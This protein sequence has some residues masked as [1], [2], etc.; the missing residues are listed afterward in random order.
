MV[1]KI[2]GI[3]IKVAIQ[4]HLRDQNMSLNNQDVKC[5]TF[6]D[7]NEINIKNPRFFEGF[8]LII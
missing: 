2:V 5:S 7:Q 3:T 6:I 1:K 8:F 4:V